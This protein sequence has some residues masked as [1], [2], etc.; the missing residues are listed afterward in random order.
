LITNRTTCVA[1]ASRGRNAEQVHSAP[2][3]ESNFGTLAHATESAISCKSGLQT[4]QAASSL[5]QSTTWNKAAGGISISNVCEC[6]PRRCE[7]LKQ[8]STQQRRRLG[9]EAMCCTFAPRD[10]KGVQIMQTM[11]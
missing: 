9:S 10:D 3:P 7:R 11:C 4:N 1:V 8:D 2:N 5:P 6:T